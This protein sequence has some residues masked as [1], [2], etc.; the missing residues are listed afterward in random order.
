MS[1]PP[2]HKD[3]NAVV[4]SP[5][6]RPKIGGNYGPP[7]QSFSEI[8]CESPV[9]DRVKKRNGVLE[10]ISIAK[11]EQRLK[12]LSKG[13][14]VN[15]LTLSQQII[16]G[17][18]DG[19]QTSEIDRL[20][21]SFAHDQITDH[22]DY[23]V[24]ATRLVVSNHHKETIAPFSEVM[25]ALYN[26]GQIADSFMTFVDENADRIDEAIDYDRDYL[27][28]YFGFRTFEAGYGLRIRETNED[29]ETKEVVYERPQHMCMRASVAMHLGDLEA[30]IECYE[31]MS[32]QY[33][34]PASPSLFNLGTRR[35]QCSS[36][37]LVAM[38][39]EKNEE[40]PDSID[41]IYSTLK[42]VALI[43]RSSG[44]IGM[45]CSIVRAEGSLIKSAGRGSAG[46]IPMLK[47]FE[48][49][50]NYVDQGRKRKGAIAVYLE[51]WHADIEDFLDIKSNTGAESR[52]MRDL[53]IA[54]WMSDLFMERVSR[55]EEWS[56]MCPYY[57][58]DLVELY[59][60]EF[61]ARY[62]EYENMGAPYVRRTV[63]AR[64]IWTRIIDAQIHTGEPY[65][66]Y[67]DSVNRKTNH[68]NLG[69]IRSS[70]LCAEILQYS[71]SDHTAVCNLSSI[72]LKRF[73]GT[74]EDGN[75]V[76]DFE[77]LRYV[78]KLVAK[79]LDR[80]IDINDY[81]TKEAKASNLR[82]RPMG[83]GV[84]GL[85]DAY[86]G[87]GYPYDSVEASR[88]NREI[89][90]TI[91]YAAMEASCD[92]A[93]EAGEAYPSYKLNGGS[94]ISQGILQFDMWR[95]ENHDV[96]L[97]GR[98]N[99]RALRSRIAKYGVRNSLM[100]ALMPTASTSQLLG[101]NEAFEAFT[102]NIYSRT[103]KAGTFK[104]VNQQMVLDLIAAG[105]WTDEMKNKVIFLGGSIQDIPEIPERLR[106]LYKTAFDLS[107]KVIIDQSADRAPFID[108]TQSL[109]IHIAQPTLASVTS[110]HMYGWRK[111]LK[112]GMYYL[113]SQP[114]KQA[115]QVTVNPELA[116]QME[117]AAEEP[118]EDNETGETEGPVGPAGWVCTR[119]EGCVSCS[120]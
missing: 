117:K 34:T 48:A 90:E 81:P 39:E 104:V 113:R 70:N 73:V 46:I 49:T 21:A 62:K 53:H 9:H 116:A 52:R 54:L 3:S 105:L 110:M 32:C 78:V 75:K 36:C 7:T 45:H 23:D 80:I 61:T 26:A 57:S 67:K 76:Y 11:I 97:S 119:E 72:S 84:Q 12:T 63:K 5:E 82:E 50:A 93:K 30:A 106:E 25:R 64:D 111:G 89:F 47:P 33:F 118:D 87:M 91:Y 44:G 83:I 59:G 66:L 18:Y 103:T 108:Q 51:I 15:V 115:A 112:T 28:T 8:G 13:L 29:N 60:D 37:F 100:V 42:R 35:Q 114:A 88:L 85:A 120:G 65:M 69:T 31:W 79:N 41:K 92:M 2:P 96:E 24:L 10:D 56:L 109:N 27:F 95:N 107:Q 40:H 68:Q 71:D 38:K 22:P 19:M 86:I 43:S 16:S 99:W 77:T 20:S 14:N 6:C 101:N 55:D 98:W 4:T 17:V 94:P 102:N 74:D 58:P 1:L